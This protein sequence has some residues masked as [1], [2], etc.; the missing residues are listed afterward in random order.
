MK[1]S[2]ALWAVAA[3]G[4]AIA[5]GLLATWLLNPSPI[6]TTRVAVPALRGLPGD[7]A[8]AN[9]A[10]VGLRGRLAGEFADPSLPVGS[11]SWQSP[12]P[13]TR[14][15]L[16]AVV[17]LGVSSGTPQVVVPDLTDLEL[18]AAAEIIRAAG[19]R[20]GRIDSVHAPAERGVI[21]GTRPD[22]RSALRAG[23]TMQLTVSL[24]PRNSR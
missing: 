13:D 17:R 21:V 7:Q 5:A 16:S 19:L 22:A 14:L 2:P 3:I 1:R 15:P 4:L 6:V 23:G 8:I 10:A 24:G 18:P 11:V 9:L 20:I 12:A